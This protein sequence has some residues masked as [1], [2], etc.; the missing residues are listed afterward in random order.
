MTGR[1][2]NA[3]T[4]RL[5]KQWEGLRLEA[6]LCQAGKWTIGWGHTRTAAPGM[7]ITEE[8]AEELLRQDLTGFERGIE[9][10]I[11]VPLTDNQFGALVSWAFNV[12]LGNVETSTLRRRLN[13]GRYEDVPAQFLVWNKVTNPETGR[14]EV[15][16]GVANRRA[17]EVGLWVRGGHVAGREET[18]VAPNPP[19]MR[20]AAQTDTGVGAAIVTSFSSLAP[21]FAAFQGMDWKLVAAMGIAILVGYFGTLWWRSKR[22]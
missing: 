11:T 5:I 8:R 17:A 19:T 4:L 10:L 14:K 12:G 7:V 13:A 15:S 9:R 1:Q 6:Y 2:V 16:R 22:Q 21:V 20:D 18:Q 3:E